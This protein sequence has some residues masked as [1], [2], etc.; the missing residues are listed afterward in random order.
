[1]AAGAAIGLLF[2]DRL[3]PDLEALLG[4]LVT[5]LFLG[6]A[7]MIIAAVAYEAVAAFLRSER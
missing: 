3:F 5:D 1:M 4:D 7:G 6:L 2:G